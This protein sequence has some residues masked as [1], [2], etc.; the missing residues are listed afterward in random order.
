MGL[1]LKSTPFNEFNVRF[2]GQ[3][4]LFCKGLYPVEYLKPQSALKNKVIFG[5]DYFVK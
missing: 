2:V 1:F 4:T 5:A 3:S